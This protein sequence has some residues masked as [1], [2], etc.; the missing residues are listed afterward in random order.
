MWLIIVTS[1]AVREYYPLS[2]FPMYAHFDEQTHYLWLTDQNGEA[3]TDMLHQFGQTA[4]RMHK[5]HSTK[6]D[7]LRNQPG[8]RQRDKLDMMREATPEMLEQMLEHQKQRWS[9]R[10]NH[11]DKRDFRRLDMW[12]EFLHYDDGSD[13]GG[14]RIARDRHHLGTWPPTEQGSPPPGTLRQ[15]NAP[16]SETANSE[17]GS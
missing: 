14:T 9:R 15:E 3:V 6:V 13:G 16:V 5:M 1:L 7:K 17:E 12:V 11:D 10:R 8:G 4:I 2:R